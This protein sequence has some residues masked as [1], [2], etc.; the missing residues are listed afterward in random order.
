MTS[1]KMYVKANVVDRL[2]KPLPSSETTDGQDDL[3][4]AFDTSFEGQQSLQ[5]RVVMDAAT[6]LGSLA[7]SGGSVK[8]G[9]SPSGTVAT[10]GKA[11]TTEKK[12]DAQ[13][14]DKFLQR[15][16]LVL[17]RREDQKKTVS[18]G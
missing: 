18:R 7:P 11:V 12:I 6:F 5:P 4:K 10:G 17:Q 2:T 16:N 9:G 15:Q 8:G 14:F 13:E 1:V 3:M